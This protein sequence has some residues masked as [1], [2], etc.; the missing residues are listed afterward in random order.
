MTRG[1]VQVEVKR[2]SDF[3]SDRTPL[4]QFSSD[5]IPSF[6]MVLYHHEAITAGA[7]KLFHILLLLASLGNIKLNSSILNAR[8]VYEFLS[9][10]RKDSLEMS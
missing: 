8:M 7:K 1:Y 6:S 2:L 4:P 5:E 3:Q 10:L 9:G